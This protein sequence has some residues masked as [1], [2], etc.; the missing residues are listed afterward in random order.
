MRGPRAGRL[1]GHD[2]RNPQDRQ[3]DDEGVAVK[4][5]PKS[6]QLCVVLTFDTYR[7]DFDDVSVSGVLIARVCI[8]LHKHVAN[9]L[10]A[11]FQT[12]GRVACL[13]RN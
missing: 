8:I 2:P 4:A 6:P 5:H 11:T 12:S 9:R 1:R 3:S 13:S 7:D 10:V